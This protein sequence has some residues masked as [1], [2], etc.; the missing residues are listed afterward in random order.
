ME[1]DPEGRFLKECAKI[2]G[3][4]AD[5]KSIKRNLKKL[6][7]K[8]DNL[9]IQGFYDQ[10]AALDKRIGALE[11]GML[12]TQRTVAFN[13]S[14][15]VQVQMVDVASRKLQS[16]DPALYREIREHIIAE[17]AKTKLQIYS[18]SEPLTVSE[19]FRIHCVAYSKEHSLGVFRD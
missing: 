7:L 17:M 18:S 16:K 2:E 10:I 6:S 12:D 1:I 5:V 4:E 13:E 14:D 8:V 15:I 3:L 11:R 19:Q 9:E